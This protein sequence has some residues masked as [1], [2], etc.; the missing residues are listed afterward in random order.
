MVF[1]M[2]LFLFLY[3][4]CGMMFV[5]IYKEIKNVKWMFFVFVILI[6][7]VIGVMFMVV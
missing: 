4:L 2:M 1:N 3:F 5:N 7:I 6:V